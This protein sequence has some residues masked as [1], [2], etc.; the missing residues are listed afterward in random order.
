MIALLKTLIRALAAVGLSVLGLVAIAATV[1]WG[2][3]EGWSVPAIIPA[4]IGVAAMVI[5]ARLA[6]PPRT[7]SQTPRQPTGLHYD[8]FRFGDPPPTPKQFGYAMHLE[9]RIR[10]GMNKWDVSDAIDEALSKRH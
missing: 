2:F 1:F 4:A 8:D 6:K 7:T 9:V 10:N 5:G 3:V